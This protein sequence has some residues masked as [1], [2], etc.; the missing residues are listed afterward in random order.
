MVKSNTVY[1]IYDNECPLCRNYCRLVR[2]RDAVGTLKLI[3]ARKPSALMNEITAHGL[4]ID[5]GMVVKIENDIYY[6]SDAIHIMAL[7]STK[8]GIF[9]RLTYWLFQSKRITST[10]YPLLREC[11]KLIL[12]LI[13]VSMIKNL[14]N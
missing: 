3:N 12:W 4:D 6:G 7:L 5:R 14:D 8:S 1:I 11:R 2:I 10:L 9:N 13:G